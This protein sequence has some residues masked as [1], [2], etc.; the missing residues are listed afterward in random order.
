MTKEQYLLLLLMEECTEVSQRASKAI[1][2]GLNEVQKGQDYSNS[3]RIMHEMADLVA[4]Y[5]M[6]A[7]EDVLPH[8]SSDLIDVKK[9]KIEKY[10]Q[11]SKEL[12]E[13]A[14]D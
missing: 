13:V 10:Y 1:R 12:G 9:E 3:Y 5:Q 7:E 11:Y 2:F 6:L 14:D 4:V 8:V